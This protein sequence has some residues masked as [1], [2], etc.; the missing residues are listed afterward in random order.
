MNKSIFIIL[1]IALMNILFAEDQILWD[2]GI[3]IKKDHANTSDVIKPLISNTQ[4]K[5]SYVESMKQL[6]LF[7]I[8]SLAIPSN[9]IINLLYWNK[10]YLKLTEYVNDTWDIES[11]SDVDR[12]IYADALYQLGQYN[13]AIDNLNL[14]SESYPKDEK[15]FMLALYNKKVGNKKDMVALLKN[16]I[17]EH[18]DSDYINLAKLQIQG[19]K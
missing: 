4:I 12:I 1:L 3:V 5:P 7:D 16:I 15:Y 8:S 6:N 17:E 10:Q 11:I 13:Q 2:L 14:L 19:L 9:H 18:P